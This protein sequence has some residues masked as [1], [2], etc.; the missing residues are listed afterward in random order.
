[1]LGVCIF[2]VVVFAI[3]VIAMV[4][5]VGMSMRCWN[6]AT[7]RVLRYDVPGQRRSSRE[8]FMNILYSI[9][10]GVFGIKVCGNIIEK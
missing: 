7:P 9:R 8:I 3:D 2:I 6:T 1:M 4:L 10:V 5:L